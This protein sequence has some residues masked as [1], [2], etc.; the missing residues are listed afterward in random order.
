M[1]A[2]YF[3]LSELLTHSTRTPVPM[4]STHLLADRAHAVIPVISTHLLAIRANAIVPVLSA[5]L[6]AHGTNAI[7][8]VVAAKLVFVAHARSLSQVDRRAMGYRLLKSILHSPHC[9]Q[10]VAL[11]PAYEF[12]V[13]IAFHRDITN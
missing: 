1:S 12:I 7:V 4:F 13:G 3:L 9:G 5:H 11:Q 2:I 8:E 6:L 10:F